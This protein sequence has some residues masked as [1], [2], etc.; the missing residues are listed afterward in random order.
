MLSAR[1][2][3]GKFQGKYLNRDSKRYK[4][5][6]IEVGLISKKNFFYG[7]LLGNMKTTNMQSAHTF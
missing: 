4:L 6:Q 1:G 3:R 2:K 7:E 5:L